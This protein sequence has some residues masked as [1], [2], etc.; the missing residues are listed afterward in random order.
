MSEL[1]VCTRLAIGPIDSTV[2][3]R[4]APSTPADQ[5]GR[6]ARGPRRCGAL[7]PSLFYNTN[8]ARVL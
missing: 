5:T 4:P 3:G 7:Y 2:A 8:Q 1:P 6:N